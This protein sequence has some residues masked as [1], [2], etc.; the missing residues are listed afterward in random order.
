MHEQIEHLTTNGNNLDYNKIKSYLLCLR[1][2]VNE[3]RTMAES[4]FKA[5]SDDI[6]ANLLKISENI[7]EDNDIRLQALTM[8]KKNYKIKF[9]NDYIK[10][11]KEVTTDMD[12]DEAPRLALPTGVIVA[13]VK[14]ISEVF[15]SLPYID[16]HFKEDNRVVNEMN[17]LINNELSKSP[18]KDYLEKYE[19]ID[20]SKNA[21]LTE[22]LK[23]IEKSKMKVLTSE[24]FNNFELPPPNKMNDEASWQKLN[25]QL[26]TSLQ[27][28]NIKN[29]NLDLLIKY[30]TPAWKKYLANYEAIISQL[31][32]EKEIL[33]N[34]NNEI[35]RQRKFKQ[36]RFL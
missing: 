27:Q 34:K 35:N 21:F 11:K 32:K 31:K 28:F 12:V 20:L 4:F 33:E 9:N 1:S 22:E 24:I 8:L 14:K 25:N 16:Q 36:V 5:N 13:E 3:Q 23:R 29:F 26:D 18:P 10:Y 6:Y 19:N 30:G 17:R 7:D 15:D 2:S